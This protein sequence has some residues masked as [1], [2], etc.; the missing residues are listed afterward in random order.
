MNRLGFALPWLGALGCAAFGA[1]VRLRVLDHAIPDGD[2]I[3]PFAAAWSLL[4]GRLPAPHHAHFGDALWASALPLAAVARS[5][6][7]LFALRFAAGASI[8]ACGFLAA[9]LLAEGPTWRRAAAAF[10]AGLLLA[11]DPG[12]LDSLV[13]GARGY[14]AP[15]LCGL[16][17]LGAA[18]AA[19][20]R[21][22]GAPLLVG[23]ALAA[24]HHHPMALGLLPGFLLFL[25]AAWRAA[26]RGGRALALAL[27][28]GLVGLAL[29]R[30]GSAGLLAGR[31]GLRE[32]ALGSASASPLAGPALLAE[33]GRAWASLDHRLT[34]G[35][36]PAGL[37]L[38]LPSRVAGCVLLS[39]VGVA[40]LGL[41]VE[42]LQVYHLRLL[43]APLA[44]AA[45]VGWARLGPAPLLAAGVA[46]A[47]WRAPAWL[48]L[49][50]GTLAELD[51]LARVVAAEP[52]PVWLDRAS[53]GP[54]G[55]LPLPGLVLSMELQRRPTG[56]LALDPGAPLLLVTCGVEPPP[57]AELRWRRGDH[58]LLRFGSVGAAHAW[59]T[60]LRPGRLDA[61]DAA[62]WAAILGRTP[63]GVER[64]RWWEA[65]WSPEG[66]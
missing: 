30:L 51:A 29:A 23:G 40:A 35:L 21:R 45:S 58:A 56:Q 62:E 66:G 52:G 14:G 24:V 8:A 38:A 12:L 9:W 7:G 19:R 39:A 27:G 57:G 28:L 5:L 41:G 6:T 11:W 4:S 2:A 42:H 64:T 31:E 59:A 25:P 18:G 50:V 1:L 37:L 3:A 60:A 33:V 15:E 54:G 43:A 65:G 48:G 63:V 17:T 55:C 47:T 34:W 20:G 36:L 46:L 32:V 53:L 44:V 26:G 49:P 16:A 61:G 13:S 22:W 10:G